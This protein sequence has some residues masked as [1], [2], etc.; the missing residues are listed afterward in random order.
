MRW[1][2]LAVAVAAASL[3][4]HAQAPVFRAGIDL[5]TVDAIVVDQ[6]G[7]PVTGFTAD[8]F[9]L[10]VDGKPRQIDAF[11]LV[12]VRTG[13]TAGDRRLPDT[14]SNDVAE[15]ARVI[16]LVV[17]RNNMR[18]G[19]GR[20]ALEG[21]KGLID[22]LSPG[23]RLGLV[24]FPGGGPVVP[25]SGDH[26]AVIDAI[27][28]IRGLDAPQ[29][30][31]Q[32]L[33][34]ISEAIRIDRR[35]P[36]AMT[37]LSERNCIG[38]GTPRPEDTTP[39]AI[40]GRLTMALQCEARIAIEAGRYVRDSRARNMDALAALETVLES[41]RAYDARK[42][43][44]YVSNGVAFDNE[45]QGR[46]RGVGARVAAAGATFY[47]IQMYAPPMDAT[48]PGLAPDW[49]EDRRI[50]GEGLDYLAGVSGGALF[51]PVAGLGVTAARIARETSARYAL[52]FQM[53]P[54]DR[55][56]KRHEIKVALRRDRGLT[57]R[58]RTEFVAETRTRRLGDVPETLGAALSAPVVLQAVPMRVATT[59]VPD[60][61][62]QPKVLMAAAVGAGALTGRYARTRLAYEVVDADGRRYG[63][64]EEV[65][66]VTP[67]YTVS[68]RLK[69]GRY[70]VKVAAKDA[71]GRLGSVEHPFEVTAAPPD[72]LHVGGAL[73]FRDGPDGTP[74]LL[75]DVPEAER[76]VGV[77]VFL[78]GGRP[79]AIDGVAANVEVTHLDEA[80][81]RFNGPMAVTCDKAGTGCELDA[82]L[83][84]S[85][86]PAG[87]YRADITLLK[88][89]TATGRVSRAFEVVPTGLVESPAS[90]PSPSTTS[91]S[92]L[93]TA[94]P[95]SVL[96]D[97]VL[98]KATAYAE[99]FATRAVSTISEE[100]Y[101]QAI[102]DSPLIDRKVALSWRDNPD[103]SRRKTPGVALRRQI[104]ADMLMVKSNAGYLVPYRDVAA[105]D[106]RPVKDRD[107]RAMQLFTS[108]GVPSTATLRRITEEGARYNLGNVR[109]T[110]NVPTMGL[111]VLDPR[112]IGRFEFEMAGSEVVEGIET[113]VLR[114]REK[115]GP[116]LIQT[117]R[118]DDVFA[119]GRLWVAADGSV[120][121]SAFQIEERD[122][123]V[124]IRVDVSYRDVPSLGLLLP[125]EMRETYTN[126]P[127]DRLRSIESRATYQ[128]FRV[129][130]VS[131]SESGG[132]TR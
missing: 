131:T 126:V 21:L 98:S 132:E 60:G 61:S 85:R 65:D 77:H 19:E 97:G 8:D 11:E 124:R 71:D 88:N 68:M 128:N 74:I 80:V 121:Q 81:S 56:G 87:R 93:P 102:V 82:S 99:Q 27:E 42:T 79:A 54:A 9:V 84:T 120:R 113:T 76:A 52:G 116:T 38:G 32:L 67:L 29:A 41:M 115:R 72:G 73:L 122:S 24:T 92:P 31:P 17:D 108:D 118:G 37:R 4:G 66:A 12:A 57:L 78:H 90:V 51:R 40:S 53:Q 94:A 49:E 127:G 6:D 39:D 58:H 59:L 63:D 110:V 105:V 109:R 129:F 125:A 55:D 86:W 114:F 46:L 119:F 34:T 30:D 44:V 117:G 45:I 103:E 69:P 26:Q 10:T 33:M 20:A 70:R 1:L 111:L 96:L 95:R 13:E 7:R 62:T 47:A 112:H 64:T 75:V 5:V 28:R 50:R 123:G 3:T 22:N 2:A 107:A 101:V 91:A 100:R 106:G 83:P 23:D 104:A 43:I 16:L 18:L 89:G 25:P 14:S 35:I 36:G 130:R 48:A 15:P